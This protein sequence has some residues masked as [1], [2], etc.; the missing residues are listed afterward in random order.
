MDDLWGDDDLDADVVEE[1]VLLATQAS[2]CSSPKP[3]PHRQQHNFIDN[4]PKYGFEFKQPSSSHQLQTHVTNQK[5]ATLAHTS[6]PATESSLNSSSNVAAKLVDVAEL[7][8]LKEENRRLSETNLMKNGETTILRTDLQNVRAAMEKRE[9]EVCQQLAS[10][11][12]KVHHMD[13]QYSKQLEASKTEMKFKELELEE[14]RNKCKKIEQSAKEHQKSKRIPTSAQE[15]PNRR[16]FL[17]RSSFEMAKYEAKTATAETG[18][19][20]DPMKRFRLDSTGTERIDNATDTSIMIENLKF[21]LLSSMYNNG[22]S[23]S[24]VMEQLKLRMISDGIQENLIDLFHSSEPGIA[25]MI[26]SN[27]ERNADILKSNIEFLCCWITHILPFVENPKQGR[28]IEVLLSE[29]RRTSIIDMMS[30][31]SA[32][33]A[34]FGLAT[35]CNR[36][37]GCLLEKTALNLKDAYLSFNS[38]DQFQA[39]QKLVLTISTMLASPSSENLKKCLCI[40]HLLKSLVFVVHHQTEVDGLTSHAAERRLKILVQ[41]FRLSLGILSSR[42]E[43]WLTYKHSSAEVNRLYTL[44]TAIS[45]EFHVPK[46]I[47]HEINV[48][49]F[50]LPGFGL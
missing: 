26:C 16:K 49:A 11:K 23:Y 12:D 40:P 28:L 2:Y 20:T 13:T 39:A 24:T 1:C 4:K 36:Q 18:I 19:Q 25:E 6:V 42:R 14:L 8:L 43:P 50:T 21:S 10:L 15:S 45:V 27:L 33:I 17:N 9:M 37:T 46:E 32:I 5:T 31:L 35:V 38:E 29:I 34:Q 7:E 48:L 3:Q 41:A 47:S 22:I 30:L 44:L